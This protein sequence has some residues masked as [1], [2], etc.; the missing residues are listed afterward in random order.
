M[1][2]VRERE[3]EIEQES[4][5]LKEQTEEDDDEMRNIYNPYYKL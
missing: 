4:S 1:E 5:G 2:T 3:E